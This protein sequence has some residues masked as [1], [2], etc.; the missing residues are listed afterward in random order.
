MKLSEIAEHIVDEYPDCSIAHNNEF[1]RGCREEFYEESLV[2]M[3]LSYYMNEYMDLCG[4]GCPECTYEVIRNYLRIRKDFHSSIDIENFN[5]DRRYLED[6][7]ID[8]TN[9]SQYG[10]LQF[11]MYMLDSYNFTEHGSSI[12]GCWLTEDGERLL[13][14]LDAWYNQ[15]K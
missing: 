14:V 11:M 6:L 8:T 15:E 3:L 7:H 2:D 12:G 1:I 4:C 10:I 9:D 13:V 5:T